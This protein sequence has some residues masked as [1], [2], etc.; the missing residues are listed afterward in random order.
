MSLKERTYRVLIV[1]AA[2]DFNAVATALFPR[3]KF[4]AVVASNVA[5]GKRLFAEQS[6]DFVV[7]N[8]PLPDDSG[9]QFAVDVSETPTTI[10]TL[11]VRADLYL[12]T[13]DKA[14]ERGVF[15]VSK[16]IAP[17]VMATALQWMTCARE[18][19]RKFEKKTL[20]LEEKIESIRYV[21]RAKLL[22]VQELNMDEADAHRYIEKQAMDRCVPK[23]E[24]AKEIIK[25]Y[26]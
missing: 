21:N 3:S 12:E 16:P 13:C 7:V 18:R 5:Q 15:A 2:A 8:S 19:L 17:D 4:E 10:A 22:L 11:L 6:F 24:I 23:L 9:V 25:T 1:S 20:S 14:T 26:S